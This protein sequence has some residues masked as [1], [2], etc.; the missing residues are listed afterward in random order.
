MKGTFSTLEIPRPFLFPGASLS[1]F[2]FANHL[3]RPGSS[4][5][6]PRSQSDQSCPGDVVSLAGGLAPARAAFLGANLGLSRFFSGYV[7]A[8]STGFLLK[9]S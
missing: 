2:T 3:P 4:P 7:I 9:R 1:K 6:S 5:A 8:I